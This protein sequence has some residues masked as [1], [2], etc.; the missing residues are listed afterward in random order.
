MRLNH[1]SENLIY[2]LSGGKI[3]SKAAAALIQVGPLIH[4]KL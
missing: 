4:R 1:R 3:Q 2:S